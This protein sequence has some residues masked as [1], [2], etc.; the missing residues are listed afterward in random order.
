MRTHVDLFTGLGGFILAA[1]A[2]G[3]RTICMCEKDKFRRAGLARAWPGIPIVE[4]VRDVEAFR[5]YK[6]AWLLTAG[7]P[8]QPASRA[9]KQRGPRDDRWLWP[10][11]LEVVRVI[12]PAWCLFENPPGL[13]EVGLG[14]IVAEMETLGYE[15]GPPLGIPACAVGLSH[16]RER[17]WILAY[18]E[19]GDRGLS[20]QPRGQ[21]EGAVESERRAQSVLAHAH[22]FARR[23][24]AAGKNGAETR[25]RIEWLPCREPDGKVVFRPVPRGLSRLADGVP[26]G[27]RN[28]LVAALG[29]SI[30]V[31]VAAEIIGAMVLAS[32]GE[33]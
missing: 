2:N 4:D 17:T 7:V 23:A 32:G 18:A 5:P 8:C 3:I 6:G 29:D 31:P 24:G 11:T 9:G 27:I 33:E 30:A 22:D 26:P 13:D 15:V 12:R 20:I 21:E 25:D 28:E 16:I 10:A 19:G 1:R 14:D